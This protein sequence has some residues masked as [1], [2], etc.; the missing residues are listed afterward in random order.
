MKDKVARALAAAALAVASVALVAAIYAIDL[1]QRYLEDVRTLGATL[2]LR[3]GHP[4]TEPVQLRPPPI[5]LETDD[6]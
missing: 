4:G 2:E 3:L 1:G 5:Q 6:R